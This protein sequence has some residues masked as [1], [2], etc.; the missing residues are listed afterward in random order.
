MALGGRLGDCSI[1]A[2]D[3]FLLCG[4][5]LMAAP[6]TSKGARTACV[7]TAVVA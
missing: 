7:A 6:C 3:I 4:E 5:L 1:V 2:A